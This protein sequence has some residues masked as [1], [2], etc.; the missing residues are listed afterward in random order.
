MKGYS[1]I[2]T[3]QSMTGVSTRLAYN[4]ERKNQRE[5]NKEKD[6]YY[7]S[8]ADMLMDIRA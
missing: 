5:K 8:F 4:R 7:R 1:P 3:V 2:M 6:K